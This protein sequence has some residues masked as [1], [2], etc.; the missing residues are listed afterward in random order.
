[1][2][3]R[4]WRDTLIILITGDTNIN[5]YLKIKVNQV[6]VMRKE[7]RLFVA[8]ALDLYSLVMMYSM[9]TDTDNVPIP[10]R[11][12]QLE[13]QA[14]RNSSQ[15]QRYLFLHSWSHCEGFRNGT[16][17]GSTYETGIHLKTIINVKLD[18]GCAVLPKQ[19]IY[20]AHPHLLTLRY[21]DVSFDCSERHKTIRWGDAMF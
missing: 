20:E 12:M 17:M 14:G 7:Y 10:K 11:C 8:D 1:M 15:C 3:G 5:F 6:L 19:I 18:S 16:Q 4:C 21:Y 13:R 9:N 2:L